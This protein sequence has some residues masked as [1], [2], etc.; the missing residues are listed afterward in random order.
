VLAAVIHLGNVSFSAEIKDNVEVAS[1]QAKQQLSIVAGLL[2]C[3]FN[4]FENL[5]EGS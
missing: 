3:F 1:V 5:L 4:N 2:V